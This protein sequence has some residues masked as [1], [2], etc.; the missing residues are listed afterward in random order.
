MK[1]PARQKIKYSLI[2]TF[3]L[4]T[5]G[6]GKSEESSIDHSDKNQSVAR[7][8]IPPQVQT[9]FETKV[10]IP[11][12][13]FEQFQG[14][15]ISKEE[16][17][18]RIASG[19]YPKTFEFKT[20]EDLPADLV[21]ED[22]MDLPEFGSPKAKKGGTVYDFIPDF[23]RTLRIFGPDAATSFRNYLLD[24][25]TLFLARRHPNDTE[26]TKNGFRCFA[27][28][29]KEWS[30]DLENATGYFRLNPDAKWS[31]GTPIT[32]DDYMYAIYFSTSDHIQA[33][34]Q[35]NYYERNIRKFIKYDDYTFALTIPERKPDMTTRLLEFQPMPMHFYGVLDEHYVDTF[36]WQFQ[37]TTGPYVI[38]EEDINK[39][40]FIRLTRNKNWWAKDLKFQRYRFNFDTIHISVIRDSEKAIEA[41]KKGELDILPLMITPW[42]H[43]KVAN[44]DPLVKNGY[45]HKHWFY[46]DRPRPTWA[47]WMNQA[48]EPMNDKNVRL[49]IQ[50][51]I[52]WKRVIEEYHRGDY[53]RMRTGYDGFGLFTHPTIQ[54]RSFDP[55][56][57]IGYFKAAG[58]TQ[59]DENGILINAQGQPLSITLTTPY[60]S[61]TNEMTIFQE[62]AKKAGLDLNLEILETTAGFKKINEKKHQMAFVGF[63]GGAEMTPR[64]WDYYHSVNAY[65]QA[66]LSDGSVNPHRKV[67]PETNNVQSFAKIEVDRL[68]EEY[69]GSSD[70]NRMREIAH[71]IQEVIHD[72]GSF[73]PGFVRPFKRGASWRWVHWPEGF[74]VRIATDLNEY[75]LAWIDEAEKTE[76]LKAMKEGKTFEPVI[77]VYDQYDVY[78]MEEKKRAAQ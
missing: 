11:V 37:P 34:F 62:E 53:V 2:A 58:Y 20:I 72:T 30:I 75:Y 29:A 18:K 45:I 64:L 68:I 17:D 15:I 27:E 19:L 28:L 57:A 47:I 73:I 14:G 77:R 46:N 76:T 42:W 65:D 4:L 9:F 6:C 21:W 33:P 70:I 54:A 50:H 74:N 52:N 26:I 25:T 31:D 5:F 22:G 10:S 44:S 35:K 36:Q 40:R 24:N 13:V 78:G 69:R 3:I 43:D 66:F 55:E 7:Q 41:F 49:G 23:P 51:A 32:V 48:V 63:S 8:P 12:D 38:H 39:G 59:R 1:K 56:K 16:L 60:A 61:F 71:E 67:K